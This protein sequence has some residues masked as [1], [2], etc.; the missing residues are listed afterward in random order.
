MK[1]FISI[2]LFFN[3][4][5]IIF[6]EEYSRY[7]KVQ[8]GYITSVDEKGLLRLDLGSAYIQGIGPGVFVDDNILVVSNQL[9]GQISRFD[10]NFKHLETRN[11]AIGAPQV[12]PQEKGAAIWFSSGYLILV[13]NTLN[14]LAQVNKTQV[15]FNIDTKNTTYL[16]DYL[17]IETKDNK[18]VSFYKPKGVLTSSSVGFRNSEDTLSLFEDGRNEKI[19][20]LK[21]E[22]TVF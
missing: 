1:Y 8:V 4:S 19:K 6:S 10:K 11:L 3:F 17:F 9:R 12:I 22:G 7:P 14:I 20:I 21:K 2:I 18:I 15:N 5:T 16:D 13:D